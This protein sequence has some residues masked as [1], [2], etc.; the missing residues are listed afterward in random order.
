MLKAVFNLSF[1]KATPEV[2]LRKI[3]KNLIANPTCQMGK[4]WCHPLIPRHM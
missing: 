1:G 3:V 2:S 4:N